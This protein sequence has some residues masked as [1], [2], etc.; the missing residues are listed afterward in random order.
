MASEQVDVLVIG[1]GP[2][3]LGAAKRLHQ[4]DTL[5]WL[6]VDSDEKA[7]GLAST[8]VTPEGFVS[9]IWNMIAY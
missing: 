2:T 6:I 3:G 4:L 8:D 9:G 7:G 5:S 1:M